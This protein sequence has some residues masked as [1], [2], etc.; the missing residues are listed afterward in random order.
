ML[1][2]DIPSGRWGAQW[3][4]PPGA[5]SCW[6]WVIT[7]TSPGCILEGQGALVDGSHSEKPKAGALG[8]SLGTGVPGAVMPHWAG[9]SVSGRSETGNLPAVT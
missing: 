5:S 9:W 1:G 4:R 3:E 7:M 8:D 2:I 6:L